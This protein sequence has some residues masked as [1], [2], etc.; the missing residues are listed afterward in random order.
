MGLTC[1]RL[2]ISADKAGEVLGKLPDWWEPDVGKGRISLLEADDGTPRFITA[3][4]Y[5]HFNYMN[6]ACN[7]PTRND[8]SSAPGSWYAEAD[9]GELLDTFGDFG[10]EIVQLLK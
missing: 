4:P 6:L 2:A 1:F 8:R 9:R 10:E 3:Y 7:F 5:R